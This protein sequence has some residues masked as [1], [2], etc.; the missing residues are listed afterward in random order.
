MQFPLKKSIPVKKGQIVALTV[1]TWAPALAVSLGGDTS[2]RA[3]RGR[4]KCEDTAGQTAQ[5]Q[6]DSSRSTTACTAPRA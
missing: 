4:G 5:T 1:A 2:W 3:A 6:P